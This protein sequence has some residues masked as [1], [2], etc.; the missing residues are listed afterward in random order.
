MNHRLPASRR[1]AGPSR[2]QRRSSSCCGRCTLTPAAAPAFTGTCP[3]GQDTE[4]GATAH[5]LGRGTSDRREATQ[6]AAA[7]GIGIAI[8]VVNAGGHMITLYRM[9]GVPYIVA[10]IA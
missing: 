8:A 2:R 7:R 5:D 9:D 3:G 6:L 4:A 10:E 1:Y